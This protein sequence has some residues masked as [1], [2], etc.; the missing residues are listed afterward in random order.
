MSTTWSVRDSARRTLEFEGEKLA[1]V[2]SERAHSPRWTEMKLYR[3]DSGKYVLS[4]VGRSRVLHDPS[5]TA[6]NDKLNLFVDEF[7]EGDPERDKFDLHTCIGETYYIDEIVV[8]E[9]RYWAFVSESAHDIVKTLHKNEG[10]V[11][12][13][14]RMSA[15]L[16]EEAV[17]KDAEIAEA[18]TVERI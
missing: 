15:N 6:I 8:E 7:P 16:L 11:R 3:T 14:P 5:C 17:P 4:K 18:F 2:S 9:T 10:G 12:S 1:E 13:L